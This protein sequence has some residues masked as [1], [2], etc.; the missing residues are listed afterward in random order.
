MRCRMGQLDNPTRSPDWYG[1]SEK[2][3]TVPDWKTF[4][5]LGK[6][7][8]KTNDA[9]PPPK[10]CSYRGEK[11]RNLNSV[12]MLTCQC[13]PRG[14]LSSTFC[15][16][17]CNLKP[18]W[19]IHLEIGLKAITRSVKEANLLQYDSCWYAGMT[20]KATAHFGVICRISISERGHMT[21]TWFCAKHALRGCCFL[22][23]TV[24]ASL[25]WTINGRDVN[26][27][28]CRLWFWK[29]GARNWATPHPTNSEG[30]I[31]LMFYASLFFVGKQRKA[32]NCCEE[33]IRKGSSALQQNHGWYTAW[34]YG[35]RLH[36]QKELWRAN[37]NSNSVSLW[38]QL[39]GK[40]RLLSSGCVVS[41]ISTAG[42]ILL[43]VTSPHLS[44]CVACRLS[45]HT[46]GICIMADSWNGTLP[47]HQQS[48]AQ[49]GVSS[50][51]H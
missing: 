10:K 37:S 34:L 22:S 23:H 32:N 25:N 35:P 4:G 40:V 13:H 30:W 49:R 41:S 20:Y 31:S 16:P 28:G 45:L 19:Q 18:D 7:T 26:T 24:P 50:S 15:Q 51:R 39:S 38:K 33:K 36:P 27:F 14:F 9:H 44:V 3:H 11:I 6:T 2:P 42:P 8:A 48:A 29:K 47:P 21:G 5:S 46:V 12:E 1:L 43:S 17:G